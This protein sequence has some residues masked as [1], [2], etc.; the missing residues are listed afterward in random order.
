[1][2]NNLNENA[3]S[4]TLSNMSIDENA[5]GVIVGTLV[6]IDPDDGS[7]LAFSVNDN[8]FEVDGNNNLKLKAGQ[9]LNHEVDPTVTLTVTGTDASGSTVDQNFTIAVN[10]INENPTSITL[11][12]A[13]VDENADGAIVGALAGVDP[14]DGDSI[15]F[16][17]SDN[18]FEVDGSNNLKLK[19][20]QSLNHEVDATVALTVSATDGNGLTVDQN[21]TI[22]VSDLNEN[23][24]SITLSN[25]SVDENMSGA[26]I[27]ALAGVDPDDGDSLTFSVS[28]N[29][30]EVDGNSN[31]KLKAGQSL[32]HEG[33][34]IVTLTVTATDAAGLTADQNF[35]ITVNN[36]NENAANISLSNFSIDENAAGATVGT[37]VGIDPDDGSSLA[38]SVSDNRFEVDGS[39]NLKLKAGQSLNHEV[40][41]IVTLTV[42]GTDASGLAVSQNFNIA[43]NDLNENPTSITLA[44]ASVDENADGAI[45]GAL[46][47]I[48]PDDGDSLIFTVSDNRFEVDGSNNLKLKAGQSLNH[49]VDAT[50]ALTV[51]ATDAN[52]LT[53]DQNFT[54]I[55]ND[56]N[57]NPTSITLSNASVDENTDGAII[58]ALTGVDPDNGDS[59]T[60]SV[61]DNR[62][63]IDGSN[64][65]KLKAGQ[66]LNHE[67]DETVTLTVTATDTTGLRFDQSFTITVNDINENPTSIA[68][69]NTSVDENIAGAIVGTLAGSDPDDGDSITFSVSDN[70]FEVDASNN[71]KLKSGVS[72]NYE[73]GAILPLVVTA[74][75]SDGLSFNHSFTITVN[76]INETPT[77]IVFVQRS[78]NENDAGAIVG[79]L[80]AVDP[81]GDTDLTYTI[82]D[83]RFEV[84]G[85][86]LKLRAGVALD[87]DIEPSLDISVTV[88]DAGGLSKTEIFTLT[89]T[90]LA[91]VPLDDGSALQSFDASAVDGSAIDES[92]IDSGEIDLG[93]V[94]VESSF[95]SREGSDSQPDIFDSSALSS[96]SPES[97][98]DIGSVGNSGF[99][100]PVSISE[101][102]APV[103]EPSVDVSVNSNGEVVFSNAG[104][105]SAG[106][107][108]TFSAT[109]SPDG[110]SLTLSMN[111]SFSESVQSYSISMPG[112]GA[113]PSWIQINPET[114][115][116]T[117]DK[118]AKGDE[119]VDIKIEAVG[120]DGEIRVLEL[121]L[122]LGDQAKEVPTASSE[123]G[124]NLQGDQLASADKVKDGAEQPTDQLNSNQNNNDKA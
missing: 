96:G 38:F 24:T 39:N 33:E 25:A 114:G 35:S 7:S 101:N 89:I 14:D 107:S 42:T 23:P 21:F 3:G 76:D 124:V 41:A 64:N 71:L 36:L 44:N 84:V 74:T 11:A 93:E 6:G 80:S 13:S 54:I 56:L 65:L 52:G 18:R 119:N 104:Q 49:E 122:D 106:S 61:S 60:F 97:L 57:E 113:L 16:S 116:I 46:A 48:D 22:A 51:T 58:G 40:D 111:D 108:M 32:D 90:N 62:F 15:T 68:L 37:L 9:S 75:D 30:F 29:R 67:V 59:I 99:A 98:S 66:S 63:E 81:D 1:M 117:I 95:D 53:F 2:V 88:E 10:D 28:D 86:V 43:V 87:A 73:D 5:A 31:L 82:S 91:E 50:V 118:A 120:E 17:V 79:T 109:Q 115:V 8:R 20:G 85:N 83:S 102:I 19:A 34:P 94:T 123:Q 27:G 103:F 105:G 112:G 12:N 4:L 72:L 47:G 100:E 45:I 78:V 55:V 110:Q 92:P 121:N 69:S 77:D 26:L 70:R